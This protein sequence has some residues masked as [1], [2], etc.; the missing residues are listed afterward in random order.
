MMMLCWVSLADNLLRKSL[1]TKEAPVTIN[2][3][4]S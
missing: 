3:S 4:Q 2:S 1:D